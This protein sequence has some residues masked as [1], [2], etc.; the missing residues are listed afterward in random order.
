MNKK[1]EK[2]IKKTEAKD[3]KKIETKKIVHLKK[4]KKSKKI[5]LLG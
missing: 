2:N 4:R 5:L 3:T 1:N